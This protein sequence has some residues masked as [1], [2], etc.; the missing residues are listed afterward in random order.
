[1]KVSGEIICHVRYELELSQLSLF[2][3]YARVWEMLIDRYGGQHYGFFLP[4]GDGSAAAISFP[5]VGAEAPS[6]IAIALFSF[7]DRA[8]YDTYRAQVG[9]DPDCV[10][11]TAAANAQPCFLRY[12]R[13]FLRRAS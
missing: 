3:R 9:S 1:M 2:K 7:P 10:E 4:G 8:T 12:E 13:S 6:N 5:G 11:I